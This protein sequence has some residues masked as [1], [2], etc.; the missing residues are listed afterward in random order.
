[1]ENKK[2]TKEELWAKSIARKFKNGLCDNFKS[3]ED[4][5]A[6][7]CNLGLNQKR[8]KELLI[9]MEHPMNFYTNE[10]IRNAC[11]ELDSNEE[12]PHWVEDFEDGCIR[13]SPD[14]EILKYGIGTWLYLL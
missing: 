13:V 4:F 14:W 1:M 10:D 8:T 6:W 9:E 11:E 7:C 2:I 12:N 3:V 5:S